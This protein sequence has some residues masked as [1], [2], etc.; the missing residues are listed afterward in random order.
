MAAGDSHV[1]YS[2]GA[3]F[4]WVVYGNQTPVYVWLVQ[5]DL[6]MCFSEWNAAEW[7]S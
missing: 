1:W 2:T 3:V 4:Y 5:S 7:F 6:P